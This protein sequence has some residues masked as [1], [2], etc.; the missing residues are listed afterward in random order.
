MKNNYIMVEIKGVKRMWIVILFVLA[1]YPVHLFAAGAL[2]FYTFFYVSATELNHQN[3]EYHSYPQCSRFY[4]HHCAYC[5]S[6]FQNPQQFQS[7]PNLSSL[8][9]AHTMMYSP[10]ISSATCFASS[11]VPYSLRILPDCQRM[12]HICFL[13]FSSFKSKFF[14]PLLYQI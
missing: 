14:D 4:H 1:K 8:P 13:S 2:L 7:V 11:Y 3:N 5:C 10:P 6:R 12:I 9:E